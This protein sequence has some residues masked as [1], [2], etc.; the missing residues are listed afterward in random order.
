MLWGCLMGTN[1]DYTQHG[2]KLELGRMRAEGSPLQR[3]WEMMQESVGHPATLARVL[4]ESMVGPSG[5]AA[6][7]HGIGAASVVDWT[8]VN[9]GQWRERGPGRTV[10]AVRWSKSHGFYSSGFVEVPAYTRLRRATLVDDWVCDIRDVEG[11]LHSKS[12]LTRFDNMDA[13]AMLAS[14]E[15][16]ADADEAAL[17]ANLG[18]K[19]I[20][21]LHASTHSDYFRRY[22]WDGRVFLMNSG[23][24]HHFAAAR[25]IAGQRGIRVPL[26][27]RLEIYALN[28]AAVTELC[29]DF[30]L[31][32]LNGGIAHWNAFHDAVRRFGA[33]W[34]THEL[35]QPL[36]A[37]SAVLLP[38]SEH[39]SVRVAE[40]L[41]KY[42]VADL[43]EHLKRLCDRQKALP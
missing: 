36:Q 38:K 4:R 30:E 1:Q 8:R 41:R 43:G 18:H 33:T 32:A 11:F 19:E 2:D 10:H 12:D 23:G 5:I 14:P 27:G 15:L 29:A 9:A 25:Y 3:V 7:A 13:M 40:M 6:P 16:V 21:I 17:Q 39:R 34:L 22:A 28:E 31:F 26:K 37:E 42:G 35:P 20:R 24:S